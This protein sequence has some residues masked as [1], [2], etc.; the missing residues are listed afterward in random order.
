[1][2]TA[3]RREQTTERGTSM[4]KGK[5]VIGQPVLSFADGRRLDTVKDLVL[6]GNDDSVLALLVDEGGLLSSSRVVPFEAIRSFG[7]DAVVIEDAQSIVSASN[8]KEINRILNRDEKLLGKKVVTDTGDGLGSISDMYFD[9][10]TGR[11]LGFEVSGGVLGDI[12]RGTSYLAVDEIER[13]GPD[14][15]FVRPETGEG[16]ENQVGGLQGAMNDAG[17]RL[18]QERDRI[19]KGLGDARD[20][21]GSDVSAQQHEQRLVGRRS[22]ADVADENGSIIVANGQRVRSEHIEWAR[23]TDN[24][25]ALARAVAKGEANETRERAG[26]SLEEAGDNVGAMWDRFTQRLSQMR[27]ENG[28]QVDEQYTRTRLAQIADIIGRPAGKVIL[29]R[30]DNVILDFG[31]IITHQAVQQAHDSGQLDA[32]LATV[33]RT[34]VVFPPDKLRADQPASATVEQASGNAQLVDELEQKVHESERERQEREERERR[35]NEAALE[36]REQQREQRI[37][38]RQSRE[39]QRE[40]EIEQ[41][42][43]PATSAGA[44]TV[45]TDN[46]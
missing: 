22:G 13:M 30:Q 32:L 25:N 10:H 35:E 45:R 24:V 4:R 12:A 42:R 44:T 16:L 5:N 17:D 31:D 29:D 36:Q 38:Q 18:G 23:R 37:Q 14:V 27:D 7:R 19:G 20:Q 28:R 9:D 11:I 2:S 1:M 34:E 43:Q 6:S 46:P 40:Q 33:V 41:A 39:Q 8:S 3:I 15:I 26:A 21:M